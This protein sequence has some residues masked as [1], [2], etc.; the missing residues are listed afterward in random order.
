LRLRHLLL[1]ENVF[2]A[3]EA[4]LKEHLIKEEADY[5]T[6]AHILE[7][8]EYVPLYDK[9]Y[10][11]QAELGENAFVVP[12]LHR[13]PFQQTL[14]EYLGEAPLFYALYDAP[15][16]LRKLLDQL[17]EQLTDILDKLA[18]FHSPY[19]EFPDNLTSSMTNPRL[20]WEFCL[21]KYQ[22]YTEIL[23]GQGKKTGS[24]TDGNLKGLLGLLAESGLDVCE[25]VSPYPL[26]ECPFE[27]IWSAWRNGPI[28]WGA[29]PSP[30]LEDRTSEADFWQWI[31]RL[32]STILNPSDE[33]AGDTGRLPILGV[34]DL[35]MRH[36]SIERVRDIAR[37]LE[38]SPL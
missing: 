14:L 15:A 13:I 35:F 1:E 28:L 32:V 4:Y 5:R 38:Q 20:F 12:L 34:V 23:H 30:I 6:A 25:S 27:E 2:T 7:H 33:G 11:S 19:V 3:T 22:K 18:E 16:P 21:P 31:E 26:T 17:D 8:A 10:T 29:I 9:V 36:N 37:L 24:H